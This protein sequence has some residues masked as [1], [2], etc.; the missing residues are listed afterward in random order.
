MKMISTIL[1]M[2]G[3]LAITVGAT[4]I[5]VPLGLIVGGCFAIV[6]GI[7]IGR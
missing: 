6:I 7:A 4:L 1:Q 2:V 5:A 3:A